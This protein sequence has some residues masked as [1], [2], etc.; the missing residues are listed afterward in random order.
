MV[1]A[2]KISLHVILIICIISCKPPIVSVVGKYKW[3]DPF[4]ATHRILILNQDGTFEYKLGG[5]LSYGQSSGYWK[6]DYLNRKLILNSKIQNENDAIDVEEF[7]NNE[8][9]PGKQR[10]SLYD[11]A[12]K[13]YMAYILINQPIN[14]ITTFNA[15]YAYMLNTMNDKPINSIALYSYDVGHHRFY[16]IVKDTLANDFK[17]KFKLYDI[18]SYVFFKNKEWQIKRGKLIDSDT[19]YHGIKRAFI[20]LN[21][22]PKGISPSG[23][24]LA[25]KKTK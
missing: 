25:Y 10:I 2:N 5:D 7:R 18:Y 11:T 23:N 20:K 8:L 13:P 9:S 6:V 17:I 16:Y 24:A 21:E 3:I 12:N 15:P 1:K 19:S 22:K 14:S 4:R